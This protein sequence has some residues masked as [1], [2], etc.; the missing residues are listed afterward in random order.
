MTVSIPAGRIMADTKASVN[1]RRERPLKQILAVSG[2]PIGGVRDVISLLF[3]SR[4]LNE[5]SILSPGETAVVL[6]FDTL[7]RMGYSRDRIFSILKPITPQINEFMNTEEEHF[8][9]GLIIIHDNRYVMWELDKD[10]Y[11]DLTESEE[12]CGDALPLP[13]VVFCL[14]V[15][16]LYLR[17]FSMIQDHPPSEG[18]EIS[19][20]SLSAASPGCPPAR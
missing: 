13:I 17:T 2:L 1:L 16:G 7:S 19:A 15:L 9:L 5:D 11:F 18:A 4:P 6:V 10:K 14:S 12:R 8:S 3:E 20:E